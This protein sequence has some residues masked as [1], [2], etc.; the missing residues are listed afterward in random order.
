MYVKKENYG[1]FIYLNQITNI[2]LICNKGIIRNIRNIYIYLY[3]Y[4]NINVTYLSL[5]AEL[6]RK[7]YVD[8]K[9]LI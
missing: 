6:D 1:K 7:V 3:Q 9:L 5:Y 8:L 4:L 2:Y